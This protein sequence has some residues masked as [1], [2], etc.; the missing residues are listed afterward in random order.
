MAKSIAVLPEI[1][2]QVSYGNDFEDYC[3]WDV[4]VQSGIHLPTF[5]KKTAVFIYRADIGESLFVQASLNL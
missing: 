1:K 4:T 2:A 5:R 3:F